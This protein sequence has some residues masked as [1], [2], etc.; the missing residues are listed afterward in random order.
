[1]TD[2]AARL[3]AKAAKA[4]RAHESAAAALAAWHRPPTAGQLAHVE[5]LRRVAEAVGAQLVLE[6]GRAQA[7]LQRP[8]TA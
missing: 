4:R 5:A 1:M 2:R 8:E 7:V 6:A 3:A